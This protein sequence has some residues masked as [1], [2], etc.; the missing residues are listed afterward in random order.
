M[1]FPAALAVLLAMQHAVG[2]K[3]R[4]ATAVPGLLDQV[5]QGFLRGSGWPPPV[6]S[7]DWASPD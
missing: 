6:K 5:E 3:S 4:R 1:A 7:T 2:E